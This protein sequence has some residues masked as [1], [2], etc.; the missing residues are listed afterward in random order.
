MLDCLQ[1]GGR[2]RMLSAVVVDGETVVP[3]VSTRPEPIQPGL[4][5]ADQQ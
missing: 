4:P 1:A 3:K 2:K 5:K